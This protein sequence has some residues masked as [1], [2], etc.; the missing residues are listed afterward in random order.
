MTQ[1]NVLRHHP[2][3]F[4][5]AT[6]VVL[7]LLGRVVFAMDPSTT[8]TTPKT[9]TATIPCGAAKE[10]LGGFVKAMNDFESTASMRG[11]VVRPEGTDDQLCRID[12]KMK[13]SLLQ[14]ILGNGPKVMTQSGVSISGRGIV[15][16]SEERMRNPLTRYEAVEGG[17]NTGGGFGRVVE[18]RDKTT[19]ENVIVKTQQFAPGIATNEAVMGVF[20]AGQEDLVQV[21]EILKVGQEL[22]VIMEKLELCADAPSDVGNFDTRP[23]SNRKY[24]DQ[25]III[26][27]RKPANKRCR[28]VKKLVVADDGRIQL[29]GVQQDVEIDYGVVRVNPGKVVRT[30]TVKAA[31]E[32]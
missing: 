11:A 7:S 16:L 22:T 17:L 6:L 26:G 15:P 19:K 9:T 25:G 8:T 27:D 12:S 1:K 31:K 5:L 20:A 24:Q 23:T 13:A 3:A 29:K 21:H 10:L 32:G 28:N 4:S 18:M 2:S 30:A 14:R